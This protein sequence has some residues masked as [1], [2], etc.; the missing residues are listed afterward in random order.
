MTEN[1]AKYMSDKLK[2]KKINKQKN[3]QVSKNVFTN[4]NTA[5]K[6][7]EWQRYFAVGYNDFSFF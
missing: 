7:S 6:V 4:Y 1:V 5:L 3:K 2:T